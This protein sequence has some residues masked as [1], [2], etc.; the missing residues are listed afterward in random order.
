VYNDWTI[1]VTEG[2]SSG[3]PLFNADW[4]VVGQ[5]FGACHF[6]GTFP[7]CDNPDDYNNVY[8]RFGFM[9]PHVSVYLNA[10]TPDDAYEDNDDLEQAA[11][12]PPGTYDLRLV[13]FNDYFAVTL[14]APAE[15]TAAASFNTADMDLNLQL[16]DALAVVLDSSTSGTDDSEVVFAAVSAGTYFVRVSRIGGWGGDYSLD[17]SAVGEAC[18]PPAAVLGEPGGSPR[19]RYLSIVPGNPGAPIALRVVPEEL[20]NPQPQNLSGSEPFNFDPLVGTRMWVGPPFLFPIRQAPPAVAWAARLQCEPYYQDWSALGVVHVFGREVM[21]SST[22]SISGIAEGC[23]IQNPESYSTPL[24]ATTARWGDIVPPYQDPGASNPTQPNVLDIAAVA[25]A[26]KQVTSE[27]PKTWGQLRPSMVDPLSMINALD[28]AAAADAV[29]G[30]RYP[31]DD[32]T[33]CP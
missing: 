26:I 32:A 25:D 2:G 27:P 7:G 22:Y 20:Q 16:L 8:G 13:D 15:I 5:L 10:V 31:F 30:R 14:A 12:L 1:G 24:I 21:P 18:P 23:D 28:I 6:N 17:L 4:E 33:G 9:Y 3:S 19:N 29:K 11:L